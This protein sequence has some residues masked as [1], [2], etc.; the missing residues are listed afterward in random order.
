MIGTYSSHWN[1]IIFICLLIV[2]NSKLRLQKNQQI[3]NRL[4]FTFVFFWRTFTN[5]ILLLYL[6]F[7]HAYAQRVP[8]NPLFYFLSPEIG[9][10]QWMTKRNRNIFNL[11]LWLYR[12]NLDFRQKTIR[13][14]KERNVNCLTILDFSMY[15]WK[16]VT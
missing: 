8:T 9:Q 1:W 16:N 5:F 6:N 15:K 11:I 7:L 3:A 13:L 12:Q 10:C 4:P 2:T 14:E